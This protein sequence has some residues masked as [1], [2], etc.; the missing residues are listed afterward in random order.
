[1]EQ[2]LELIYSDCERGRRT[3]LPLSLLEETVVMAETH[4]ELDSLAMLQNKYYFNV[5]LFEVL[6]R[7]IFDQLWLRKYG[8]YLN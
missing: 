7:K 4:Y 5:S 2:L 3:V 8:I 1:M 6:P